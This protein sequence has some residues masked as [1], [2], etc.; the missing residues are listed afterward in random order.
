MRGIIDDG[1]FGFR[2]FRI[3]GSEADRSEHDFFAG[4]GPDKLSS[5]VGMVWP[6]GL[7]LEAK[8]PQALSP[9]AFPKFIKN[10]V[11]RSAAATAR[12]RCCFSGER[13]DLISRR[14]SLAG[15]IHQ[16]ERVIAESAPV[17]KLAGCG[18]GVEKKARGV[19]MRGQ[20]LSRGV[21]FG[22]SAR[23]SERSQGS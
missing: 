13:G 1:A 5:F 9:K 10:K 8:I 19:G 2:A 17:A 6:G 3:N 20:D 11:R 15:G 23:W 4:I 14:L 7:D 22:H 16:Y 21:G 18:F 12:F